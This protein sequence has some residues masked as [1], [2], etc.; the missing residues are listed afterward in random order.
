MQKLLEV[1]SLKKHFAVEK[2]MMETKET[3]KAVDDISFFL[4]PGKI[5]AIVGESGSGKTTAAR[6]IAGLETPDSGKILYSGAPIDYSDKK[7]R[8]KIQYIFQDTYNSLNPR[9]R[10]FDIIAEPLKFH[11]S[12]SGADLKSQVFQYLSRVNIAVS[13]ADKYPHELSGGQR[14]RAGIAR[15]LT[16]R[17]SVLI[18][19]EPVS[20]LDVSIQAQILKLFTELNRGRG[21]GM[22]FITHDLRVVKNLA[23]DIIIMKEGKIVEQGK[24]NG[25]Y[26]RPK[27][28]YTKLLLSSIPNSPYKFKV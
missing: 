14:Q 20:S 13:S 22:I 4:E 16:M 7:I 5:L 3:V 12:L 27:E 24:V 8:R 9:M 15:A 21:L 11:F 18:A 28:D 1:K 17:P 2:M 26:K 25:V 6:C 23:D 10:I 19:D